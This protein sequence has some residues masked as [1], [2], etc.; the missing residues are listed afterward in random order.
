MPDFAFLHVLGDDLP[1]AVRIQGEGATP[2][3]FADHEPVA[4]DHPMPLRFSL[5]GV[6]LKFSAGMSGDRLT[7][8]IKGGTWIVK[9]PTNAYP[10]LPEN[11]FA[12]MRFASAAGLNVPSMRLLNL[13]DVDNLPDGLPAL[14]SGEPE[15]AYAIER[16]DRLS[17]GNRLHF[18]DLNQ[19]ARQ[20]PKD[21]YANNATEYVARVVA[22]LCPVIDDRLVAVL[23]RHMTE[24]PL[25]RLR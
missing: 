18:E 12:M 22:E 2:E 17:Q 7:I 5:A 1:G 20:F 3:V 14:R 10:R 4:D 15:L 21:K 6:Q 19:I 8:P 11:E 25:L 23:D 9:L 16:F 24:V 13:T